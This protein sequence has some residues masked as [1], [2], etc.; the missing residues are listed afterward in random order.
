MNGYNADVLVFV[1][2]SVEIGKLVHT[3]RTPG[4]PEVYNRNLFGLARVDASVDARRRDDIERCTVAMIADLIAVL[5]ACA[6]LCRIGALVLL[7]LSVVSVKSECR[8]KQG[9][10]KNRRNHTD[11]Q[12]LFA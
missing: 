11:D 9:Y 5:Q 2:D 6:F 1:R 4:A 12:A 7:F 10:H 3:R 8:D